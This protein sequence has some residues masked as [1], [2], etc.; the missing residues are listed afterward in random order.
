MDAAELLEEEGGAP[1]VPPPQRQKQGGNRPPAHE[2]SASATAVSDQDERSVFEWLQDIGTGVTIKIK[3]T[4]LSPATWKGRNVRGFLEEFDEPFTESEIRE[5]F[6][7]G[8]YQAK[9]LKASAKGGGWVYAGQR[10]FEVA[11]DP[12]ASGELRHDGDDDENTVVQPL[13]GP[14]T[15]RAMNAIERSADYE[16]KRAER[17]EDEV[18]QS[19]NN[20]G[21]DMTMLKAML[22]P[23]EAQLKGLGDQLL[24]AQKALADKDTKIVELL[25]RKPEST[26]QDTL[27][28]KMVD[29]E[30]ARIDGLRENHASELR[31]LRENHSAE[32]RSAREHAK[33][34]LSQ[35]ETAHAREIDHMNRSFAQAN[36]GLKLGYEGR[37]EALKS[38]IADLEQRLTQMG[39]EL[40]SLRDKK[41]TSPIE[42]MENLATLK[43][44]MET[45]GMGGGQEQGSVFERIAMGVLDSP[46]VKAVANRVESA[47]A[48]PVA[49]PQR[50]RRPAPAAPVTQDVTVPA[51][52]SPAV[53]GTAVATKT[54][55]K[56][57]PNDIKVAVGFMENAVRNNQDPVQFA[58]S[59]KSM[60]PG[61]ILLVIKQM[62]VEEFLVKVAKV[63]ES[64]PLMSM[65]GKNFMRKVVN[66]LLKGVTE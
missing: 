33:E 38:R 25:T 54:T 59:A 26:F 44:A 60:V 23:M 58:E 51:D 19:R 48:A 46:L 6:G 5:R 29:G 15:A 56:L 30:S 63:D 24:A 1:P 22:S 34:E 27:L 9:T 53:P 31:Q 57:N 64:S 61:D 62:G 40:G 55:I 45:L 52:G 14:A 17:L 13:E 12:K 41:D 11:G 66:Y 50:R 39:V 2:V 65:N 43:N 20:S 10:T 7:G 42:Q 32:M 4:R 8:K 16:R 28:G 36:D 37:I 49:P 3:L 47:P 35:R 21:M 18:R